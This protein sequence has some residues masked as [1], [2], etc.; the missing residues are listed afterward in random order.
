MLA[1]PLA[2]SVASSDGLSI[3]QES[4]SA[5]WN[6]SV[7]RR[8]LRTNGKRLELRHEAEEN[9]MTA[10]RGAGGHSDTERRSRAAPIKIVPAIDS[11]HGERAYILSTD[12]RRSSSGAIQSDRDTHWSRT[13]KELHR[14]RW[15][16][17]GCGGIALTRVSR[18]W[19]P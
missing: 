3:G 14:S 19:S 15:D 7:C 4:H 9:V 5:C 12:A 6:P 13:H 17:G 18:S 1:T 8:E 2:F 10:V 11:G 16:A